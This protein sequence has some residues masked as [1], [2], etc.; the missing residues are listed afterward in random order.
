MRK[1]MFLR[2]KYVY[3]STAILMIVFGYF[4]MIL[5]NVLPKPSTISEFIKYYFHSPSMY[6]KATILTLFAFV[7]TEL[8]GFATILH[9]VYLEEA[10]IATRVILGI[11]GVTIMIL[12]FYFFNYFLLL[13]TSVGVI[14]AL[15]FFLL[16][17]NNRR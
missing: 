13:L 8:F 14:A 15:A 1:F 4:A 10:Y 9:G 11:L 6:L 5:I 3:I 7:S 12:A 17:D 16:G 2:E